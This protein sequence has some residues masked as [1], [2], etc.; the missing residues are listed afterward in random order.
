MASPFLY[1]SPGCFVFF[2]PANSL[3]TKKDFA[4][5]RSG[6]IPFSVFTRDLAIETPQKEETSASPPQPLPY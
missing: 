3:F 5:Y 1:L 4:Y 6:K 2:K